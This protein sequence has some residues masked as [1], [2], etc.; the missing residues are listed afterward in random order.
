MA[1]DPIYGDDAL[2]GS[3]WPAFADNML[4][5]VFVLVLVIFL[6]AVKM[7]AGNVGVAEIL[8]R[9]GDVA[10]AIAAEYGGELR[11]RDPHESQ[12]CAGGDCPIT[13]ENDIQLQRITFS[14]RILFP[15]GSR[16]LSEQ[17]RGVLSQVGRVVSRNLDDIYKIQIE[18]HTDD[19]PAPHYAD[20]NL[21]LGALRAIAVYRFLQDDVGIDPSSHLMSATSFGEYN[22]VDRAEGAEAGRPLIESANADDGKRSRNRRVEL[23]LFYRRTTGEGVAGSAPRIG[24]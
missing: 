6:V 3:F 1:E 15:T 16:V 7:Q 20:G 10:A 9:Q 22:P 8:E 2:G 4:A 23:L 17:G 14:D 19:V 11:Q 13:I 12:V 21:E 24:G 18:G 5:L